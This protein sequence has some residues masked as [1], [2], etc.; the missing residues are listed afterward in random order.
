MAFEPPT[1]HPRFDWPSPVNWTLG[2]IGALVFIYDLAHAWQSNN[3]T[4]YGP[5]YEMALL[6]FF[7]ALY[8][9]N[10]IGRFLRRR[11]RSR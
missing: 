8:G 3:P 2:S 11:R 5:V 6:L 4:D 9:A 1:K 10:C 7:L